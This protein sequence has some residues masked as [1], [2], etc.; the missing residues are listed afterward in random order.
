MRAKL[1]YILFFVPLV[2]ASQ[3][4]PG[5]VS[6][7]YVWLKA[8]AGINSSAGSVNGWLDQSG[9]GQN[10]DQSLGSARPSILTSGLNYNPL[11]RFDGVDD[12]M[13]RAGGILSNST[14]MA[15]F[16]VYMVTKTNSTTY[17][18]YV[19]TENGTGSFS[20]RIAGIVPQSNLL[21][22]QDF[23]DNVN[24]RLWVNW[25]GIGNTSDY[26]IWSL[27]TST[28]IS[29]PSGANKAIYRNGGLVSN[30]V[31]QTTMLGNNSTFYMGSQDGTVNFFDGDIA[32]FIVFN[33]IP[34]TNEQRQIHSYL[35]I[36][37]GIG[38]YQGTP[39]D[40]L[41]SDGATL[42]WTSA[43]ANNTYINNIAGIGR[44]NNSCLHQK[45]SQGWGDILT[46]GLTTIV[47]SNASNTSSFTNLSFQTWGNDNGTLGLQY[48]DLPSG[49]SFPSR[50]RREWK[51]QETGT[52]GAVSVQ[53]DISSSSIVG[54]TASDFGLLVDL[55][56]DGD[57]T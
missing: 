27:N 35:A 2:A 13:R 46:I 34:T 22:Y 9:R 51:I 21:M 32:E 50:I 44:D 49:T 57:F 52:V 45:Q 53:F 16:Y 8:D 1:F 42:M 17:D 24:G 26:F 7:L 14:P 33:R 23:G 19:Y 54:N 5:N 4:S 11:I 15:D 20:P 48:N 55:D 30:S 29:T 39:Q 38:L 3:C 12:F 25:T 40:Y 43:K 56:G 28:T 36:K 10:L 18:Q 47:G 41:A 6:N 37:Y 31:A